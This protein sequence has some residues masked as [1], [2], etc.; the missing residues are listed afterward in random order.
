MSYAAAMASYDAVASP[1]LTTHAGSNTSTPRGIVGIVVVVVKA[2]TVVGAGACVV[3][4]VG[5]VDVDD[6]DEVEGVV[7]STPCVAV[8]EADDPL[9]SPLATVTE[10]AV[11]A[12]AVTSA[13]VATRR[14][15]A[16]CGFV[17]LPAMDRRGRQADLR[18]DSKWDT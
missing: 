3:G 11:P 18:S 8:G 13:M 5:V 15:D 14:R 7:T 12:M 6:G 4:G 2:G 1:I 10:Q 17:T 9:S 16:R